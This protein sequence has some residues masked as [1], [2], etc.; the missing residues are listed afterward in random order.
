MKK[1]LIII[2]SVLLIIL[3]G[4]GFYINSILDQVGKTAIIDKDTGEIVD[5]PEEKGIS[6]NAP[7]IKETGIINILLMG[8]D[9]RSKEETGHSDSMMIASIDKKQKVVKITSLMRDMY[10]PIPGKKDN[11]INT[12]YLYGGP[13]LSIKTVNTN[14]N[15]NI[16]DYISVDF[17]A[18]EEIINQ[19]G[20]VPIDIKK[21][22][23]KVI[24]QYINNLNNISDGTEKA[25]R[26]TSSGLQTLTG[27]QAVAYSRVRYVGRDDFERTERQRKVLNEIFKAGKAISITK[28]P[29]LIGTFLPNVETS[30]SKAEILDIAIAML[31]FNTQDIEQFRI[32]T[33]STYKDEWVGEMLVLKPD[34]EANK[35]L[36]HE[37]IFGANDINE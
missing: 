31:G 17:F 34:I 36:L 14:F 29:D 20:G 7:T 11:R 2:L 4:T 3:A 18:L 10:V 8:N 5:T 6:S 30:L 24:N 19:V 21:S 27:R 9:R 16:E 35:K 25:D 13:A 15:M 22:E 32:P 12:A 1:F 37:F 23:I 28:V 33:D 26:I